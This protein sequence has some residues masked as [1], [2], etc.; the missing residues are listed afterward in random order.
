MCGTRIIILVSAVLDFPLVTIWRLITSKCW[1]PEKTLI[2]P[3]VNRSH[4][5]KAYFSK[6]AGCFSAI[7]KE[8]ERDDPTWACSLS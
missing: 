4:M 8:S 3:E 7:S 6:G 2:A 1:R 5:L